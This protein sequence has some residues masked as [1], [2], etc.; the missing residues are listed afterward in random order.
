[1]DR[2]ACSLADQLAF[3]VCSLEQL[4]LITDRSAAD[5]AHALTI[6]GY[7]HT[8]YSRNP[9]NWSG[10]SWTAVAAAAQASHPQGM[11]Q[12]AC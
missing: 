3:G 2:T 5:Q 1:M 6:A 10:S 4:R 11:R 9:S 8:D 12:Q 7:Q